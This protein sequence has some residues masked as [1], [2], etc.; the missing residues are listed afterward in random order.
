[1]LSTAALCTHKKKNLCITELLSSRDTIS[2][3]TNIKFTQKGDKLK[4]LLHGA[5]FSTAQQI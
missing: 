4:K 5:S 3:W 2:S 1:M